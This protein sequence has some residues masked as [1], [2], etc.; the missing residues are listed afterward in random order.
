MTD[1]APV[2]ERQDNSEREVAFYS[3]VV[4]AWIETKMER[5]RSVFTLAAAGIGLL[6]SVLTT[7]GVPARWLLGLYAAAGGFFFAT[8]VLCL[9]I[10]DANATHLQALT[11]GNS[12]VSPKLSR[13]DRVVL[14]CFGLGVALS[15]A[16][17]FATACHTAP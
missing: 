7:V 11:T 15:L 6:V 16:I 1:P 2:P 12:G 4:T 3:A 17:A 9:W 5:D 10:F 8:C 13:L 14:I